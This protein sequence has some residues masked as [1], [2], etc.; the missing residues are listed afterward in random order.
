MEI[1][2]FGGASVKDAE[3][4]KNVVRVLRNQGFK[5]TLIVI[6]AI[7]KMTNAFEKIINSYHHKTDDLEQNIAFVRDYHL[8]IMDALFNNKAHPVFTEVA[9]LFMGLN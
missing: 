8:T 5:N 2:K 6:S 3:G 4:I 9:Q 7:G 1:Y